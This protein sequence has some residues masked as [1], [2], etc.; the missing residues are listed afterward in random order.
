MKRSQGS[1][2][3]T[4][5][6]GDRAARALAEEAL[7]EEALA[8][9]ALAEEALAGRRV[10]AAQAFTPLHPARRSGKPPCPLLPQ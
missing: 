2:T 5:K 10:H 4:H 3:A 1:M 9:E 6:K 8:E 7:A